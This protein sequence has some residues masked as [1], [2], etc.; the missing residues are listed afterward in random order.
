[1][2]LLIV[3]LICALSYAQT[4]GFCVEWS[5]CQSTYCDQP[6]KSYCPCTCNP[7]TINSGA[8]HFL[9]T[10]GDQASSS[11]STS[12]S[13]VDTSSSTV[14]TSSSNADVTIDNSETNTDASTEADTTGMGGSGDTSNTDTM[15]QPAPAPVSYTVMRTGYICE[16][17]DFE[18]MHFRMGMITV[19]QCAEQVSRTRMCSPVFFAGS[20]MGTCG[21]VKRGFECAENESNDQMVD[22]NIYML[23]PGT[24]SPG[25]SASSGG[26][27]P[28]PSSGGFPSQTGPGG[29]HQGMSGFGGFDPSIMMNPKFEMPEEMT[30]GGGMF[31]GMGMGGRS[32]SKSAEATQP[33][34]E[35]KS[36]GPSTLTL[37]LCAA[38]PALLGFLAGVGFLSCK[39]RNSSGLTE[40]MFV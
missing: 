38:I 31:G 34:Q 20:M 1:M 14:D 6:E 30:F 8:D 12:D 9:D 13:P 40:R 17:Q 25:S 16:E 5:E 35:P 3:A 10:F 27:R 22:T 4:D 19:Q 29:Y 37:V 26:R 2:R 7:G 39:S 24:G 15:P 21:C 28:F 33:I 11:S 32:L 23:A 36:S 18:L